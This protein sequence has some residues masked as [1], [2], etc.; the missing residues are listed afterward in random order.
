MTDVHE[1]AR[2]TDAPMAMGDEGDLARL[3]RLVADQLPG[4][5][6][7]IDKEGYHPQT[8]LR[9][10]GRVYGFGHAVDH[11]YGGR[12]GGL[13][14]VI[15]GMEACSEHCVS[16]G[17]LVWCQTSCAWYLQKSG[18]TP[19]KRRLLPALCSG[20]QAAGTGLSNLLKARSQLEPL[21]LR[22][23]AVPGGYRIHG[24]LP[25][26]SNLATGAVFAVAAATSGGTLMAL[27]RVGAPGLTLRRAGP[28]CAL[29]GTSTMS[30]RFDDVFLADSEVIAPDEGFDDYFARMRAGLILAQMGMALGLVQ[31]ALTLIDETH[32]AAQPANAFIE[33][34]PQ[35][36]RERLRALRAET[37]AAADGLDGGAPGRFDEILAIR[38]RGARLAL[39]AAHSALLHCGANGYLA[40]H[41]A[42][43]RVREAYFVALVTPALKHL[44]RE[45]ALAKSG[46]PLPAA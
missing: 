12:P 21:R 8:F 11:D 18:N 9:D 1:D 39:D 41:P 28:F 15:T 4:L 38:A 29:E 10:Y 37:L 17:F 5:A 33:H 46:D 40:H 16:T 42:Q 13:K 30:C 23:V 2:R 43:R 14:G 45:I 20:Q 32:S 44:T 3:R 35:D 7:R 19:L 24:T 31:G 26:V 6:P 27:A 22:A 34:Q 25:W 36:L